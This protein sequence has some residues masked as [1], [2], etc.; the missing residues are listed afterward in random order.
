MA[1][2]IVRL[3]SAPL[4]LAALVAC[5]DS[6]VAGGGPAGGSPGDGGAGGGPAGGAPAG[7]G[8]GSAPSSGIVVN[9]I[10]PHDDEVLNIREWLEIANSSD[11]EIDLSGFGVCD[12]DATG[13]CDPAEAMR[14]PAGTTI[15]A[16]G[17]IVIMTDQPNDDPPGPHDT[18]VAGVASCF[19][20]PWKV[21]AGDGET[22][23]VIDADN[24]EVA[25]LQY[26]PGATPDATFS[27]SRLP[28]MTGPGAVG[29]PT[30][31]APNTP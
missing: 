15:A 5:G 29:E 1:A 2:S 20:A 31:G 12:E 19:H 8:G 23:R 24:A 7:G 10:Q 3:L 17:Y 27:F 4:V 30:P 13:D 11:A 16:G 26:P 6:S 14:F 9:E 28:D 21:S 22:L 18:C 25:S